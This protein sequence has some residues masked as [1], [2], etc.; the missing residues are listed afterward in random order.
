MPQII[1][2]SVS[3]SGQPL[4]YWENNLRILYDNGVVNLPNTY[5]VGG[6]TNKN[7]MLLFSA[8]DVYPYTNT[9]DSYRF[10]TVAEEYSSVITL[11][12]LYN[13]Y[14]LQ[15]IDE[16]YNKDTRIIEVEAYLNSEDIT[17]LNFNDIILIKSTRYR[18]Y[19]IEYRAGAMR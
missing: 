18:I 8:M 19:K 9:S 3:P 17:K 13:T 10:N 11:N 4:R 1:D 15:Y 14:W 5:T 7:T 2:S 12:T 16:L 6:F